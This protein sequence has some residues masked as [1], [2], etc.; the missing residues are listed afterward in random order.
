MKYIPKFSKLIKIILVICLIISGY[1]VLQITEIS[2]EIR[3]KFDGKR[4]A[5]PAQVYARPLEIY[6]GLYLSPDKFVKELELSGYRVET[7]VKTPGGYSRTGNSFRLITRPFTFPGGEE[8][9]KAIQI[10]FVDNQIGS[11]SSTISSENLPFVRFDPARIGS[12]HPLIHEDR[13]ILQQDQIPEME[14]PWWL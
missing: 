11:I 12:F 7:D 13:V 1:A 4:W 3:T 10:Q 14:I 2:E 6:S 9:A 8:P 5:L